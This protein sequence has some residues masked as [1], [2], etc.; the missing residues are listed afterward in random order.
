MPVKTSH[1]IRTVISAE[2]SSQQLDAL[3]DIWQRRGR[4]RL[5]VPIAD[6]NNESIALDE[7][8][9]EIPFRTGI[10]AETLKGKT[11]PLKIKAPM[12]LDSD[13]WTGFAINIEQDGKAT[14]F[15]TDSINTSTTPKDHNSKVNDEYK[16]ITNI[17]QRSG[18]SVDKPELNI[19]PRTLKQLDSVSCGAY[20]IENSDR[21]LG[22]SSLASQEPTA[23]EIRTSQ[24]Q[25]L[26]SASP[27]TTKGISVNHSLLGMTKAYF[28][29][30][31]D[32]AISERTIVELCK[33]QRFKQEASKEYN[34]NRVEQYCLDSQP[35]VGDR[36]T[37]DNKVYHISTSK[38]GLRMT[39]GESSYNIAEV[40]SNGM[41]RLIQGVKTLQ[42]ASDEELAWKLQREDLG[43]PLS[44]KEIL[45][46][47][48]QHLEEMSLKK[49]KDLVR[50]LEGNDSF[51]S[52]TSSTTPPNS[53][54]RR[55]EGGWG[56]S[57]Q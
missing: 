19:Y 38:D 24:L 18:F 45:E 9:N 3:G 41:K 51:S 43:K 53:K 14:V 17:L 10:N 54:K 44:D 33:N 21:I 27:S 25:S 48:H 26:S 28:A 4:D 30:S 52:T 2:Y 39:S 46:I 11:P 32:L 49:T 5:Y 29:K 7:M 56:C 35:K 12:N 37:I 50:R 42:I 6:M 47:S 57:L 22:T 15:Y 20:F 40:R 23:R 34:L 31:Q 13:H 55:R 36:V 1:G 16:R 8:E